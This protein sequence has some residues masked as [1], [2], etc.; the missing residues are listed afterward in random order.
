MLYV[1]HMEI[2]VTPKLQ[3]VYDLSDITRDRYILGC[4]TRKAINNTTTS[5]I[6]DDY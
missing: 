5:A 6:I 4:D 2:S 3:L 1:F